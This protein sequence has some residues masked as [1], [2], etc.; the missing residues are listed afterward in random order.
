MSSL[1]YEKVIITKPDGKSLGLSPDEINV[2]KGTFVDLTVTG[3]FNGSPVSGSLVTTDAPQTLS[4]KTLHDSTTHF[5]NDS[6]SE[7]QI[8]A[9]GAAGTRGI[10]EFQ[11][12]NNVKYTLPDVPID[13][14]VVL[15]EGD[16]VINGNKTFTGLVVTGFSADQLNE[17]TAG[18][19][20]VVQGVR[21]REETSGV[22]GSARAATISPNPAAPAADIGI[23]LVPKGA[24]WIGAALPDNAPS[25]GAARGAYAIDL[26]LS[27]GAATNVA[28]GAYSTIIG[29]RDNTAAGAYSVAAGRAAAA[30][31]DGSIVLADS[32]GA[33]MTSTAAD[34]LAARFTGGYRFLGGPFIIGDRVTT[35]VAGPVVTVGAG[36]TDLIT[37][38]IA[39]N[40][41]AV[42]TVNA[43]GVTAAGDVA[44]FQK[45]LRVKNIAGVITIGDI[46]FEWSDIDSALNATDI[47]PVGGAPGAVI[48]RA[49]GVAG[50]TINW[51]GNIQ[52]SSCNF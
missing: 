27:R 25:G 50:Q 28:G 45:T 52:Q 34:Q 36:T 11:Q 4:N 26:Q 37:V 41:V 5:V 23:V 19:G 49:V 31:H 38:S 14:D 13:A 15:T 7:A 1:Y 48:F 9:G 24:G 39:S 16:Q 51:Y 47:L 40:S 2:R 22:V 35:Y 29:G 6:T 44:V 8:I 21:L 33:G 18:H 20:I 30:M 12:S 43:L 10:L 17:V 46:I 42:F 3:N 32:T